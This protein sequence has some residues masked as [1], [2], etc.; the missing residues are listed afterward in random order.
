MRKWT[1]DDLA[2][3]VKMA[4][5]GKSAATIGQHFSTTRNAIIGLC[6]RRGIRLSGGNAF[7]ID[8]AW[9]AR[10]K[11][12]AAAGMTAAEIGA[13]EGMSYDQ[14][15]SRARHLGVVLAVRTPMPRQPRRVVPSD[16]FSTSRASRD[17][18]RKAAAKRRVE[19]RPV[20][21]FTTPSARPVIEA[22]GCRW[23]LWNADTPFSEKLVC[24]KVQEAGG[25]YCP[26][27][28][29]LA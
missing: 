6:T 4:A 11:Q 1:E 18:A 16:V 15:R 29:S 22:R 10:L 23:P 8:P 24:G 21:Q 27:H 5:D 25:S 14:I 7:V 2:V 28:A 20:V 9:V 19:Q 13:L 3:V 12:H 17:A 26:D